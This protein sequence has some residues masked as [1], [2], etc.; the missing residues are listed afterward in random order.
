[1]DVH[2]VRMKFAWVGPF[3]H[4]SLVSLMALCLLLHTN[5]CNDLGLRELPRL[6]IAE[7]T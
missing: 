5:F 2:M 4:C 7:I 1:M 6:I 3:M